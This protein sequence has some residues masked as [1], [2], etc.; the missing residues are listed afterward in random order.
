MV[1]PIRRLG[2]LGGLIFLLLFGVAFT[3]LMVPFAFH[4]GNRSTLMTEWQGVGRLRD[5]S[6][7]VYGLHLS[8]FPYLRRVGRGP[9]VGPVRPW[10]RYDLRGTA[11]VCTQQGMR[12]PFDVRGDIFG[13]WLDADGKLIELDLRE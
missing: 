10:P 4:W 9:H 3:A 2:C 11:R 7:E 13:A 5:S 1:R 12:I 8:F 6:G